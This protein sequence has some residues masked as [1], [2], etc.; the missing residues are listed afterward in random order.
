[1]RLTY[2]PY[3]VIANDLGG[4]HGVDRLNSI[5]K[6]A[7]R[8]YRG[9]CQVEH[10][11]GT[12][13]VLCTPLRYLQNIEVSYLTELGFEKYGNSG[14]TSNY[15]IK[16]EELTKVCEKVA[17][18]EIEAFYRKLELR[19]KKDEEEKR[20]HPLFDLRE[21]DK[22]F[23]I[24]GINSRMY[25]IRKVFP[26]AKSISIFHK[27]YGEIG[28]YNHSIEYPTWQRPEVD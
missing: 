18:K 19:K 14:A 1:M 16:L 28:R 8:L 5:E 27:T 9:C 24:G 11:E 7:L 13:Y 20:A 15:I 22:V 26:I 6:F 12:K 23:Q 10:P 2:S 21:G 4:V 17:K 3:M 25:I